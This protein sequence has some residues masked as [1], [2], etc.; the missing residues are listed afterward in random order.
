MLHNWYNKSPCNVY[1]P[2]YL[3]DGA[4]EISL[5]ANQ[6][7]VAHSDGSGI[8]LSHYHSGPLSYV[9]CLIRLNKN[10]LSVTLNK[11]SF[12]RTLLNLVLHVFGVEGFHSE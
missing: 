1:V 9:L 2:F 10:V 12:F 5:A 8:L 11:I 6:K 3:C 7:R 4:F